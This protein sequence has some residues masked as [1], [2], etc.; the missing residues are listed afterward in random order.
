MAG[1]GTPKSL[2]TTSAAARSALPP[3]SDAPIPAA[4]MMV[5]DQ[6]TFVQPLVIIPSIG[7]NEGPVGAAQWSADHPGRPNRGRDTRRPRSA[8]RSPSP[9]KMEK[10]R[11]RAQ[12]P[13][14]RSSMEV[15]SPWKRSPSSFSRRVW[16][17]GLLCHPKMHPPALCHRRAPGVRAGGNPKSN[18]GCSEGGCSSQSISQEGEIS[19]IAS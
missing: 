5:E 2:I 1:E 12:S 19:V 4:D 16:Q 11:A 18:P 17:R 10:M 3:P 15:P 8:V 13:Y 6:V 9:L 14:R 7:N